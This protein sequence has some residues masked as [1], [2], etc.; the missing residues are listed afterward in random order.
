MERIAVSGPGRLEVSGR[1]H[2]VRGRR[3]VR[4]ALTLTR[5]SDGSAVRA[6]AELDHKPWAARDGEVW[7][8]AFAVDVEPEQASAIELMV[9]PDITVTLAGGGEAPAGR[10]GPGDR[11]QAAATTSVPLTK[12]NPSPERRRRAAGAGGPDVDRLRARMAAAGEALEQERERRRSAEHALEA[13][14]ADSRRLRIDLGQLRAELELA[15]AGQAEAADATAELD[16]A[17][18][19][20]L[21]T[22]QRLGALTRERDRAVQATAE[23]RTALHERVGALES[24]RQALAQERAETDRLR[25]RRAEAQRTPGG[26]QSALPSADPAP[27]AAPHPRPVNP[28]LRGHTYWTRVL[29]VIVLAAVVLAVVVV[30]QSTVSH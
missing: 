22:Q 6:F 4:P 11:R 20:L 12:S 5:A 3:F 21:E 19:E 28:P 17:R 8:A 24:A 9:A 2:G 30:I 1:W 13:E 14:R 18:R 25:E 29:A 23:I 7:V 10:A 27:S 16:R 26:P 15:R